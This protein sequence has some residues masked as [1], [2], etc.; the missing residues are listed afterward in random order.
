MVRLN[1][2][3]MLLDNFIIYFASDDGEREQLR[4]ANEEYLDILERKTLPKGRL[5]KAL[6]VKFLNEAV[7]YMAKAYSDVKKNLSD[8]KGTIPVYMKE[9]D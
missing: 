9:A 1:D 4:N 2:V 5:T 3:D 6:K 8:L 7:P